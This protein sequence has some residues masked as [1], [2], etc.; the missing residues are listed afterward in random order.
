MFFA[1]LHVQLLIANHAICLRID[2]L[3]TSFVARTICNTKAV[4]DGDG[5]D[6]DDDATF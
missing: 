2:E 5:D 3:S 6:G 4:D 1:I